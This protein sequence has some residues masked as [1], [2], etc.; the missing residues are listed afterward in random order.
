MNMNEVIVKLDQRMQNIEKSLEVIE[1]NHLTHMEKYTKWTL[2]GI[3][4]SVS[5]SLAVLLAST[6]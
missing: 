6:K 3:I 1:S 4:I 5:L 2:V